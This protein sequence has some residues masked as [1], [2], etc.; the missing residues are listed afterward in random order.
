MEQAQAAIKAAFDP[1]FPAKTGNHGAL[2]DVCPQGHH[3]PSPLVIGQM[4]GSR[5]RRVRPARVPQGDDAFSL[6]EPTATTPSHIGG[7]DP[8]ST[9][10]DYA[11]ATTGQLLDAARTLDQEA[12]TE[13]SVR[14]AETVHRKVFGIVRNHEDTE[15]VVQEA[16][17][18][19]YTHLGDFRGSCTFSTWLMSIAINTALMLLR[20]RRMHSEVSFDQGGADDQARGS[21]EFPDPHLDTE[22]SYA[23]RRTMDLLSGAIGRLPLRY[24]DALERYHLREQSMQQTADRL[25]LTVAAVKSRLLRG[26]L[27]LRTSLAKKGISLAD[28]YF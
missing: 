19:A 21:W 18:K 28:A 11:R 1:R 13:L 14:Y 26:R 6:N 12:F 15:D 8:V 25:G 2:N 7:A 10:I 9:P 22:K 24:R 3:A 20:K 16:L 4:A 5:S 27:R 17:F 23:R